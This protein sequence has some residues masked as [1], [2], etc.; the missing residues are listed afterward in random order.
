M[1]QPSYGT[2]TEHPREAGMQESKGFDPSNESRP[3]RK[4]GHT[5]SV[6]I[7]FALKVARLSGAVYSGKPIVVVV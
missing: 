2:K 6:P 1:V 3:I 7:S 5:T 4:D